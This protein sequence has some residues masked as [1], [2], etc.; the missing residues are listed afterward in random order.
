MCAVVKREEVTTNYLMAT[1][2]LKNSNPFMRRQSD[3]R[4]VLSK[5]ISLIER[6][7]NGV[8]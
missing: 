1:A 5:L 7:V 4:E 8:A 2:R 6:E 3:G